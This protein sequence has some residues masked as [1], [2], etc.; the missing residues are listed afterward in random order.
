MRK[1]L[2]MEGKRRK[3]KIKRTKYN[4]INRYI[5]EYIKL[6]TE[7]NNGVVNC[8]KLQTRI[9]TVFGIEISTGMLRRYR[10]QL[11]NLK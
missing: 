3:T 10:R 1:L 5:H 7:E 6:S 2:H 11:G 8:S 9:F 4:K